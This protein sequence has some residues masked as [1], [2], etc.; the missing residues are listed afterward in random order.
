MAG[1]CCEQGRQSVFIYTSK[2]YIH[3]DFTLL[4]MAALPETT[5]KFV[6]KLFLC[7]MANLMIASRGKK[8]PTMCSSFFNCIFS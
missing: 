4:E 2:L 3:S 7:Q 1:G 6:G 5:R 8:N